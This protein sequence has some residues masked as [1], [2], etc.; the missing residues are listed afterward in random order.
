MESIRLRV[1]DVEFANNQITVREGKGN[2]DRI[3]KLPQSLKIALQEHLAGVK[4]LHQKDLQEVFGRVYLPDALERKY[5]NANT[6][7]G[8]QYVFPSTK[9]S[10]DR[11]TG[12]VRRH[13]LAPEGLQRA[14]KSAIKLAQISKNGS[15]HTFRHSFASIYSKTDM[16]S[17][18]FR[19]CWVTRT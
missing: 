17:E 16:T 8:W 13:H 19:N 9:R 3:T 4:T 2:V 11:R 1:K 10:L 7:W 5:I 14:V 6:E 18:L 12:V 15:C